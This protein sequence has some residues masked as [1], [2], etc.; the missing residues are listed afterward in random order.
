MWLV[1]LDSLGAGIPGTDIPFRSEE[2][3]R[4]VPDRIDKDTK[5]VLGVESGSSVE[6]AATYRTRQKNLELLEISDQQIAVKSATLKI[7]A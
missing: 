2:E 1:A 6:R 7:D 4:V 3:Y 5:H